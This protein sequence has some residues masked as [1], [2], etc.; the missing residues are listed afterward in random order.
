MLRSFFERIIEWDWDD[1]PTRVPIFAG[2]VPKADD[3]LPRFLD[4]PT[5]AKFMAVLAA[6]RTAA[7]G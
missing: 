4:D 1:A 5:A 7:G 2:D 6:D 3:P